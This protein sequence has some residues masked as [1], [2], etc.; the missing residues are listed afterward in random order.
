[1]SWITV[2]IGPLPYAG[3][4][5]RRASNQGKPM[6]MAL[7]RLPATSI[8]VATAP[9]SRASSNASRTGK[10]ATRPSA[11]PIIIPVRSSPATTSPIPARVSDSPRTAMAS[12][13]VPI[14]SA[15]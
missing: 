12:L 2:A 7:A 15:I 1:M 10:K 9:A 8:A 13:W 6:P 3:S 14:A 4:M 11:A 5:P